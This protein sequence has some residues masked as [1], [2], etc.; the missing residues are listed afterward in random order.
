M[1]NEI[2]ININT[3]AYVVLVNKLEQL[4]RSALPLAIRGTLNAAAFDVKMR[5]LDES[6]TQNFIRRSPTFFKR[7]SGVNRATGWNINSM[8]AEVGM[9]AEGGAASELAARVA[10]ANMEAQEEGGKITDGLDYLAA[11][12]TSGSR[13]KTVA[14]K[15]RWKAANLVKGSFKRGGTTK[16]RMVAAAYIALSESKLQKIKINGRNFYRQVTSISK[17]SK[18]KVK[19]KSKLIYVSRSG[20]IKPVEATHFSRE[21]AERT[22]PLIP[23][24]FQLQ[25]QKQIDRLWK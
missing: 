14:G 8:R 6:A 21:A 2:V 15:R 7:F 23:T 16:S 11:A 25:A 19:I 22:Q 17:T 24:Y 20:N 5:T 10:V 12:R 18:G 9:T 13:D 1:A 4:H 3:D